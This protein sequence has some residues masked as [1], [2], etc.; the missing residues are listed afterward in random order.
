M[1]RCT[2]QY[3][4]KCPQV[5]KFLALSFRSKYLDIFISLSTLIMEGDSS[6]KVEI[7]YVA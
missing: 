1:T 7:E 6:V 5:V 2:F 4:R 3:V